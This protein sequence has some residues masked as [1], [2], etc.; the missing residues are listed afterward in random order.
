MK[1]E[2]DHGRYPKPTLG[3]H[4][5]ARVHMYDACTHVKTDECTAPAQHTGAVLTGTGLSLIQTLIPGS[6]AL[7]RGSWSSDLLR[8]IKARAE[9]TLGAL[10]P[11]QP[12]GTL[13]SHPPKS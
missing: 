13:D 5:H 7:V 10:S 9:G 12:P 2:H 1:V 4:M 11:T 3:L 8:E 6:R